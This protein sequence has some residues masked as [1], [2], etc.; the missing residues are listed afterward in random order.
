MNSIWSAGTKLPGFR[1]LDG[2]KKT[3]VL[4]IGGGIAGL[5]CAHLLARAGVDYLLVEARRIG[6]GIT[7]NTTAKITSQHG[8]IYHKLIQRFG[9]EKARMYLEA[10][11]AAL[12]EYREL[13]RDL[14]CGFEPQDNYVYARH[15]MDKLQEELQALE[16]LRFPAG[17]TKTLP[18]PFPV[19]GA[20][21]FPDQ[22]QFHPLQFLSGLAKDLN[23]YEHTAVRRIDG[24]AAITEHGRITADKIIVA[25]HFPFLNTHGFYFTKLYQQRSYVLALENT[26]KVGGMYIDG[27]ENGLSFRGYGDL[28]LLG[29]G[30]H[31]TG[32]QG[33]GWEALSN[34][35]RV[36]YP[37]AK[38]ACR[39]ATQDCMSLDGIP[40]I[41]PYFKGTSQL[42]VA[43][44]FNKW[45]MTSAMAAAMILAD[46]V[47][48]K[49]N[50]YAPVFAPDRSS[51]RPQL[52]VN[53]L[54][55]GKNLLTPTRPRC[56]HLGCA[57]KW[58]P[59]EH[60]W[61]CPCHGSRFA[62]NGSLIDNP[63]T[64]NLKRIRKSN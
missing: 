47:Q 53:L 29:G 25:T 6:S 56:P 22:A 64:G 52:F 55:T 21:R 59:Q 36:H 32:K 39:W 63:A 60:S 12:R 10:N 1:Q 38:E 11:E 17:F 27:E 24:T 58:N 19:V 54:E 15:S 41:G 14:S 43:T 37:H 16:A 3:D 34:F 30:G 61:D 42:Y 20:I 35:A 49:E 48:G 28:L 9:A 44:G 23:I 50:P 7:K 46:L 51:L 18:L 45:G 31:R 8:L 26:P 62:E 2:D 57:L 5:L 40:Y 13:C 33:G 4:I